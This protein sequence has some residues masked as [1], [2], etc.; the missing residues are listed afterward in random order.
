MKKT[1]KTNKSIFYD[2]KV[3]IGLVM[4]F[5][6]TTS[7]IVVSFKKNNPETEPEYQEASSGYGED[8]IDES[9]I[10]TEYLPLIRLSNYNSETG[11]RS[12]IVITNNGIIYEYAFNEVNVI[13]PD[14]D[15]FTVN[16]TLYID[17][18][19]KELGNVSEEDLALLVRYSETINNDYDTDD[20]V[21]DTVGNSISVTNYKNEDIYVLI[22]NDGII[23]KNEN[24]TKILDIINKYNIS[25]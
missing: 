11:D 16:Q 13:Y 8:G 10:N 19:V 18:I 2:T 25:L 14:S 24:T 7:L 22:N 23:N 6:L 12:G 17:N 20:L 15:I 9:T 5:T 4:L 21:F 3:I 1:K